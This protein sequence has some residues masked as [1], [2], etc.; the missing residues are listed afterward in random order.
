M[1]PRDRQ[2]RIID[3]VRN[4][5]KISVVELASR[6]GISAE[7]IRRDLNLLAREGRIEKIHG[8]A[9]SKV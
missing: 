5:G 9:M 1:R 7:T 8:S 3:A 6:F 2:A 4:Q